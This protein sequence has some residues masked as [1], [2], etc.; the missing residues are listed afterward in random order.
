M[1]DKLETGDWTQVNWKGMPKVNLA[2]AWY[3]YMYNLCVCVFFVVLYLQ[4][5]IYKGIG[6]FVELLDLTKTETA[7]KQA[8]REE[9]VATSASK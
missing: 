5:Y 8:R 3:M 1:Q 7:K 6:F 2:L 9:N 4:V